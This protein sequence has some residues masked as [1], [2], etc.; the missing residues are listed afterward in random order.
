MKRFS[1]IEGWIEPR[2]PASL[3][4]IANFVIPPRAAFCGAAAR[5]SKEAVVLTFD[6]ANVCAVQHMTIDRGDDVPSARLSPSGCQPRRR[7][8]ALT[9]WVATHE[10]V[11]RLARLLPKLFAELQRSNEPER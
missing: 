11:A 6:D 2:D 7:G 4:I 10:N 8:L 9:T 1:Y 5:R 3:R